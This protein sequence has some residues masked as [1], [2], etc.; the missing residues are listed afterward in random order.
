VA[1]GAAFLSP[2]DVLIRASVVWNVVE[3][4]KTIADA[5]VAPAIIAIIAPS[6]AYLLFLIISICKRVLYKAE[7]Y[8]KSKRVTRSRRIKLT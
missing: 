7:L 8:Y 3:D 6:F 2:V 1:V 4:S 5:S